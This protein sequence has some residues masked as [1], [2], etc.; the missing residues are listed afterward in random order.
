MVTSF[1]SLF[2]KV[3]P[4]RDAT[5]E[6]GE[7]EGFACLVRSLREKIKSINCRSG[8]PSTTGT[9]NPRSANW[10]YRWLIWT[11][12]DAVNTRRRHRRSP[13]PDICAPET[14]RLGARRFGLILLRQQTGV[15]QAFAHC[16]FVRSG[17]S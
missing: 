3:S 17:E 1:G 9:S 11:T 16:A 12:G 5:R 7:R 10:I 8:S 15:G 13:I 2:H 14:G 4:S 6:K